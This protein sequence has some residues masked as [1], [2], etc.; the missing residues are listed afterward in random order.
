MAFGEE[1]VAHVSTNTV[2]LRAFGSVNSLKFLPHFSSELFLESNSNLPQRE[3]GTHFF[4]VHS[5]HLQARL[6]LFDLKS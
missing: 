5:L 4:T 1:L 6:K 2:T 3:S